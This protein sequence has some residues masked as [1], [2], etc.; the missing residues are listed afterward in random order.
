[1]KTINELK[2]FFNNSLM[3]DL[4]ILEAERKKAAGKVV[5]YNLLFGSGIVI[6]LVLLAVISFFAFFILAADV[7]IWIIVYMKI[8][9]NYTS[10]FKNTVIL[11]II[12]FMDNNLEYFPEKCIPQSSYMSS[13]IFKTTPDRYA[14]DD[15]VTGTIGETKL[16]FSELH[17]EY[18]TES[19]SSSG[20]TSTTWHTIFKGIFFIAD[21]N[22][23]FKGRTFVL[24]DVAQRMFGNIIGNLF[25][26]WNKFRGQLVKME[27]VDFEKLFVV[28]GDD[29]IEARY[30]LS[31]SLL[32]R[33]TDFKTRTKKDI[34][35]SFIQNNIYVA[36]SYYKNL[37][38]PRLFK[39]LIDFTMIE[40]YYND[41][42]LAL[43]IVE[44]LNLNTRIWG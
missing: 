20:S 26:S 36:I 5:K 11:K 30:I 35:L 12:K 29:Q 4:Q 1:M 39:T 25:Q 10:S 17:S 24:P 19:R 28:Y 41:L 33:I 18:K 7:I 21:F 27:D 42:N 8:T 44:D 3:G 31:T 13:E 16:I 15:L 43:S 32:K 40:E 14:G 23:K 6:S 37:F 9:R 34:Y 22:K 38:E 2:D